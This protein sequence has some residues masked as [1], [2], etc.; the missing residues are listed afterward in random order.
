LKAGAFHNALLHRRLYVIL[1]VALAALFISTGIIKL[2]DHQAFAAV[3]SV[4]SLLPEPLV[5]ATAVVLPLVE[6]A[7]GLALLFNRAWGLHLITAML[8]F[9]TFILGYGILS[10]LN[11][12]AGCFGPGGP[13]KRAGLHAAFYRDLILLATVIPY[14]YAY[15][16]RG[17]DSPDRIKLFGG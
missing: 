16:K 1:R 12:D 9:F 7:A 3:I 14:L 15:R 6:T 2:F 13:D 5:A 10:G 8:V 11:V 17:I 4:Y